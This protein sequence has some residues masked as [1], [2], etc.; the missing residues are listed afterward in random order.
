MESRAIAI[1]KTSASP[2]TPARR[3]VEI[4][5]SHLNQLIESGRVDHWTRE[6][7]KF[8]TKPEELR[9]SVAAMEVIN[10]LRDADLDQQR[11]LAN[12]LRANCDAILVVANPAIAKLG[13]V[14]GQFSPAHIARPQAH[15]LLREPPG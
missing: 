12:E 6:L 9:R 7:L 14:P 4:D 8:G 13:P 10:Q 15:D 5:F 2:A 3:L 1:K 11:E